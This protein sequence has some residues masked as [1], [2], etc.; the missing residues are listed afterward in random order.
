MAVAA[1]A[2]LVIG[3]IAAPVGASASPG[4]PPTTSTPTPTETTPD[5]TP[6]PTETTPDPSPTP[7]QTT[8]DP[9][10]T[11]TPPTTPASTPPPTTAPSTPPST[12]T[13]SPTATDPVGEFID[14]EA[15]EAFAKATERL[16]VATEALRETQE[17]L[18]GADER[19]SAASS[20][21]DR[22]KAAA[23]LV[24]DRRAEAADELQAERRL[25]I[26]VEDSIAGIAKQTYQ[27]GV[28][29]AFGS[30][31]SAKTPAEF[32]NRAADLET[33]TKTSGYAIALVTALPDR[34]AALEDRLA[35]VTAERQTARTEMVSLDRAHTELADQISSAATEESRL[36]A[37]VDE[38]VE[39]ARRAIPVDQALAA[40]RGQESS[41]LASEIVAA[42]RALAA[43][44]DT[45]EGTGSFV[46]PATGVV[47]SDYG[48][49]VHPI[50][51][52][53]KMHTGVDFDGADDVVYAADR[54]TVIMTVFNAAYG[55]VT[56]VDHGTSGG[57]YFATFYAHQ[58]G[59]FVEPGDVVE[60]GQPIGAVGSTGMST[61]PHLHFEVRLEGVPVDPGAFLDY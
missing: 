48:M 46:R 24:S 20:A 37:A 53:A 59:F 33:V 51:G 23:R 38:A 19:L 47:T 61:G 27:D 5:P 28:I 29:G 2:A 9:T 34:I 13:P 12:S 55:N 58:S 26:R 45:V 3:G 32:A 52:Y 25:L 44:G 10:P 54:G 16:R 21:V 60:K 18:V 43:A 4:R 40:Q 7:T 41:R 30:V 1:L 35:D 56:V 50:L 42:S 36:E 39:A 17:L 6:T 15:A 14:H 11:T 49:R 57:R 8:T 22:A 31:M